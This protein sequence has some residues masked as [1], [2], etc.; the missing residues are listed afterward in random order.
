[1]NRYVD[2]ILRGSQYKRLIETKTA[3]LRQ[4][5]DLK[6]IE[7]DVLC[8]LAGAGDS[9]TSASV[10]K[11]INANKGHV[12]QAVEI[13]CKKKLLIAVPDEFDRRYVHYI[14]TSDGE[15]IAN[16]FVAIRDEIDSRMFA[17]LS[18]QELESFEIITEKLVKNM[19]CL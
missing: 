18:R 1:M 6:K 5:Y 8:C 17:S 7:T 14:I 15:K 10:C 16:S 12:S 4:K 13:L 19:E 3:E 9:N 2:I 11:K